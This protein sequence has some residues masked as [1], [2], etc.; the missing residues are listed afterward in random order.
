MPSEAPGTA[1]LPILHRRTLWRENFRD[2]PEVL[3]LGRDE[4]LMRLRLGALEAKL[5]PPTQ[6]VGLLPSGLRALG[7]FCHHCSSQSSCGDSSS[8][9]FFLLGI[10]S[11]LPKEPPAPKSLSVALTDYKGIARK[12][13]SGGLGPQVWRL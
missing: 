12:A 2:F 6:E 8:P 3:V 7:V 10:A 11:P 1:L 5:L 13:S 4:G 9:A